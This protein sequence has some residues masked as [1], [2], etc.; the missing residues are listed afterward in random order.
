MSQII[1]VRPEYSDPVNA[2]SFLCIVFGRLFFLRIISDPQLRSH[3]LAGIKIIFTIGSYKIVILRH[4]L[5]Q[6][7]L[8]LGDQVTPA[9]QCHRS[10]PVFAK[11]C[12][13]VFVKDRG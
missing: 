7:V 6:L 12:K 8:I 10:L 5:F 11:N 4:G 3:R 2:G 9:G 13:K 1:Y